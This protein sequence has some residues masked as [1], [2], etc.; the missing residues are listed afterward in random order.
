[1]KIPFIKIRIV[2]IEEFSYSKIDIIP[3][4]YSEFLTDMN[5]KCAFYAADVYR[6]REKEVNQIFTSLMKSI[7]PRVVLLGKHGVGKSSVVMSAVH[8]V[9]N[10]KAP[11]E[12]LNKH[13]IYWDIEKILA[14]SASSDKRIYESI[15]ESF[16]FILANKDK[17]VVVI[18]QIHLIGCSMTLLYYF[19]VFCKTSVKIIGLTTEDEFYDFLGYHKISTTMDQIYV[20]EP[21]SSKVYPMISEYVK[22]L[23]M[24]YET[25]IS[26]DIIEY[27]IFVSGAFRSELSNPGLTINFIEKSMSIAKRRK[28]KQVTKKD[29]NVNFNFNYEMYKKMSLEDKKITAYHEAGHFVVIKMSKNIKNYKTKAIT[30][31]PS[32]DFL[33]ITTSEFELEKQTSCDMDYFIDNIAIDLAGRVAEILLQKKEGK[34][35]KI[36]SGAFSDLK[37]ATRIARDIITEYGMIDSCGKNMTFFCNYDISDLGLLSEERKINIDTET[38][39]LIDEAFKRAENILTENYELLSLIASELLKNDVLDEKDLNRLC[40]K[41]LK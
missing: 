26:E 25:S 10:K 8:H 38:Q 19:T 28:H 24:I 30:I 20:F 2:P 13:F 3:R 6:D 33:G 17:I 41:V 39:K 5:P 34:E 11:K 12:L 7:N 32:E 35:V 27:I 16:Q 14:V 40:A 1:M 22:N 29:V 15:A 23:E 31:V 37:N 18:D 4:R 21:K 9:L 36:T